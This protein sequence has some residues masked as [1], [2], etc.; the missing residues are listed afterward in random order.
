MTATPE[1]LNL[2]LSEKRLFQLFDCSLGKDVEIDRII[3]TLDAPNR[4]AAT[5]RIKY[6]TSKIAPGGW[7]VTRTSGIGRGAT[8]RFKMEKKF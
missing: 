2:T 5:V 6:F 7:I 4:Q 8:G 1:N 3:Q